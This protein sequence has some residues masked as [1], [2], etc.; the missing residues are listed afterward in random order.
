MWI[1]LTDVETEYVMTMAKKYLKKTGDHYS[2]KFILMLLSEK[3]SKSLKH[4]LDEVL[5]EKLRLH[6]EEKAREGKL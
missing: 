4:D 1:H 5:E 3:Y 6:E 2:V